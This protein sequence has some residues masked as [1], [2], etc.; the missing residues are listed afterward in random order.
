MLVAIQVCEEAHREDAAVKRLVAIEIG[1]AFP[2]H[3]R[4]QRRRLQVGDA[5]LGVG[6]IGD[7]ER[8]DVARA[9]VALRDPLDRVVEVDRFL[10]R[11]RIRLARR[12]ARAARVDAHA[13]IAA[14]APPH[15]IGGLPC[16]IGIGLLLQIVRRN[17]QLVLLIGA[18]IHDRRKA[19]AIRR[20]AG[21]RRRREWRRRA[22]GSHVLL[23][24]QLKSRGCETLADASMRSCPRNIGLIGIVGVDAPVTGPEAR[25]S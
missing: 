12:F 6:V 9:P 10:V 17:P 2:R 24:D 25:W 8:A 14:R 15:R 16:E 23:D 4:L 19:L 20:P 22:T 18:D 5:P 13:G 3:D 1:A 7:A 11:A 21:T